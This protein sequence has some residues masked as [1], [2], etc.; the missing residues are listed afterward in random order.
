[1][2]FL[3]LHLDGPLM[4]FGDVLVDR[5]GPTGPA[6]GASLLTGLLANALGWSHE[7]VGPLQA[8][9][10]SLVFAVRLDRAGQ[11]MEDFHTVDLGQPH[12]TGTGWTT[13]GRLEGRGG[14]D[15]KEGT[16]IRARH[17]W[18]DRVMTLA[19]SVVAS[20]HAP[21]TLEN[22]A[23][24][25]RRPARPLFIGRKSCLPSRPLFGGY[26]E[27]GTP[28]EAATNAP[29]PAGVVP[30]LSIVEVWSP[31]AEEAGDGHTVL[32]RDLR[33]WA[34]QQHSGRRLVRHEVRTRQEAP[35]G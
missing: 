6:P 24:A 20:P 25:I 22:L 17:Y 23:A 13:R 29:W 31:A 18:A 33:R 4:S 32:A 26:V 30:E 3:V 9:Q 34:V 21:V 28:A 14:G 10:D 2:R 11:L 1:M 35:R 5:N 12:L 8:L 27:A 15:A 7:D 19:V 16:H